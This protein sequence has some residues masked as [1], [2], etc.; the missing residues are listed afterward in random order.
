MGGVETS[1]D[2]VLAL[3]LGDEGLEFCG[4]K[5]V[6]EAGLRDNEKEDLGASEGG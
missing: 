3:G 6:D 2:E 1:L 5:G 4:G